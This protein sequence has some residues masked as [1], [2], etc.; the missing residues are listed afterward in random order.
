MFSNVKDVKKKGKARARRPSAVVPRESGDPYRAASPPTTSPP[1]EY[2]FVA[3]SAQC[4]RR[5][6]DGWLAC[7][8]HR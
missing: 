2:W 4:R 7:V 5:V 1:L 3:P 8:P 6:T